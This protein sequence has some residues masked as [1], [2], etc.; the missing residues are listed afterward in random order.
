MIE[1]SVDNYGFTVFVGKAPDILDYYKKHAVFIDDKDLKN[2]GTEVYVIIS[3]DFT[4]P[5][6]S[7]IAF[8]TTSLDYAGFRP[9]LHYEKESQTLF[10]GAG[11][12]IKTFRLRDNEL[13]FEK[14]YGMGFWRWSKYGDFILQRGEIEFGVFNLSGQL[15]WDTF[16]SPPYNVELKEDKV[17]LT[18]DD[19]K[20]IRLLLTGH[21][22]LYH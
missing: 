8:R 3:K 7:I 5:D 16:V 13:V 18:Y 14:N 6:N 2:E 10:V 4:K 9:C 12:V 11:T 17:T 19:T 20:D 1:F 21:K 22:A 15:L